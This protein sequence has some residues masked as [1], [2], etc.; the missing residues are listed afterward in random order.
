VA[1]LMAMPA[2]LT[3]T[4]MLAFV[5]STCST[6]ARSALSFRSA[7][8]TSTQRPVS[9]LRRRPKPQHQ[10]LDF[11]YHDFGETSAANGYERLLYDAMIG[12]STFFHRADIV[13]TAWKIASPILDVWRSGGV[14]SVASADRVPPDRHQQAARRR[15]SR[16][17][18]RFASAAGSATNPARRGPESRPW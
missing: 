14:P 11:S 16:F 4:V 13:E 6:R 8:T 9:S 18:A 10:K 12:D 1:P 17:R 7:A 15:T 5:R 2:L 3:R